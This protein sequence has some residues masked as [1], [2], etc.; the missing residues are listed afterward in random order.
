M[1]NHLI[2]LNV[3]GDDCP[4]TKEECVNHVSKRLGTALRKVAAE[5][6]QEGVITYG[7]GYGKLTS[8][9]IVQLQKYYGRAIWSHPNDLEGMRNAVFAS[10]LHALSTDEDPHHDHCPAG[11][12]SCCFFRHAVAKGE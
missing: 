10:L 8:T 3:Y 11:A 12:A 1:H 2:D 5:G 4:V 6:H 9:A 7:K